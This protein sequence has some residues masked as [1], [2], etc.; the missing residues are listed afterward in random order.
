MAASRGDIYTLMS[1]QLRLDKAS[2]RPLHRPCTPCSAQAFHRF[3]DNASARAVEQS[4]ALVSLVIY[5]D[6]FV[7]R[8]HD[9][10]EQSFAFRLSPFTSHKDW[11]MMRILLLTFERKNATPGKPGRQYSAVKLVQAY[12]VTLRNDKVHSIRGHSMKVLG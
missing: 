12:D 3:E 11:E 2:Q 7:H 8:M 5:A 9:A 6:C 1:C 4:S 10:S